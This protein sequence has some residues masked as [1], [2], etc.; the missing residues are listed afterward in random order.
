MA[1]ITQVQA[2][3]EIGL[4][5]ARILKAF[6]RQDPDIMLTCK[7]CRSPVEDDFLSCPFCQAE[8]Q[9]K[10]GGCERIVAPHWIT[11]PTCQTSLSSKVKPIK[12]RTGQL[13]E[14]KLPRTVPA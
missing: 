13:A 8:L 1:D 2:Q 14:E 6:L 10:C 4:T 12:G 3:P 9:K 5:F 7:T 11:C